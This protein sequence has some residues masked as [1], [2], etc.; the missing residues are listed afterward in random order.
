ML[1][2]RMIF[3]ITSNSRS[4]YHLVRS[5]SIDKRIWS[6]VFGRNRFFLRQLK[7]EAAHEVPDKQ[8]QLHPR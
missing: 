1:R 3:T 8:K 4:E 2:I 6:S 7:I 5:W